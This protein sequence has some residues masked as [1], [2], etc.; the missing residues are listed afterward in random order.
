VSFTLATVS[1]LSCLMTHSLPSSVLTALVKSMPPGMLCAPW[2]AAARPPPPLLPPVLPPGAVCRADVP[3][4]LLP[5][6]ELPE[7]L[8]P[9][10]P[11]LLNPE[12]EEPL[13][14]ELP[15]P[16]NPELLDPLNPELPELVNPAPLLLWSNVEEVKELVSAASELDPMPPALNWKIKTTTFETVAT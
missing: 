1:T 7:L 9:E 14:P 2:A 12:L 11:E 6:L 4:L 3:L 8:N 13:N 15:E 10:L 16:L 5:L